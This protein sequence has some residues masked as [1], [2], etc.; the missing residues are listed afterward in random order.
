MP[1]IFTRDKPVFSSERMLRKNDDRK[2]SI[3]KE[4]EEEEGEKTLVMILNGLGAKTN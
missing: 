3:K 1:S 4:E 2:V